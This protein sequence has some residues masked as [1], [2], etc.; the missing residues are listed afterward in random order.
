[1]AILLL[2]GNGGCV[3]AKRAREGGG[4]SSISIGWAYAFASKLCSYRL[5]VFSVIRRWCG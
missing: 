5:E 1:M 3:G 2:P 4:T